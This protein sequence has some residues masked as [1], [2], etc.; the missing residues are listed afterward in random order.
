MER[1]FKEKYIEKDLISVIVPVYNVE[2]YIHK[3]IDSILNQTYT[4]LEIILVDDG[5]L[6]N[7]GKICD[8]YAKQDKRIKVIHK[9][10]GGVSSARN[11]GIKEATGQWITFVD[12]DDWLED[13]FCELLL[14]NATK[15]NADIVLC[16]YNR[17]TLNNVE[18]I[19]NTNKIIEVESNEYLKNVLNPQTG[20]GFCHMKL[21]KRD[22]IKET[23]FKEGL[24]V[25]EDALFNE[26]ISKK[27]KKTIFLEKSLYNYRINND[28]VV[29]KFDKNYAKKY[30]ESMEINKKYIFENYNGNKEIIQNYYNFVAFHVLLI[31]VNY[32]YNKQNKEKNKVK[33]LKEIC[34]IPEFREG[35][36]KCN[37]NNLSITRKI[38]LF[39]IKNKL[40]WF[41]GF[42]CEYRQRQNNS[43]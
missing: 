26:Q 19:K 31:A 32:C 16:G 5:S 1:V 2:K 11:R 34:N 41:T 38:T 18:K 14:Y 12:S 20:F 25:G 29:K 35:I 21:Y 24:S 33:L 8:E 4:N 28:S 40:Y 23:K 10:N 13:D 6:D 42:I 27:I 9:E 37:Y 22:C 30:L 15:Y 3:C 36:I 7:C 43:K 17:I 39:T